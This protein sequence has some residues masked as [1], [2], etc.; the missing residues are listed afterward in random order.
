[1]GRNPWVKLG[2]VSAPGFAFGSSVLA[3]ALGERLE[4]AS[5]GTGDLLLLVQALKALAWMVLLPVLLAAARGRYRGFARFALAYN[6]ALILALVVVTEIFFAVPVPPTHPQ[7]LLIE[8]LRRRHEEIST[9][10]HGS[11]FM[12]GKANELGW[13]DRN[14]EF[15][16]KP[17]RIVFIGDSMLEVRSRRRLALRVEDRFRKSRPV[18]VI[19][20]SMTGSDPKDYRF[21]LNE[22]ALDYH[23][24]HIFIFLYGPNDFELTPPYEAYRPRAI[25]VTPGTIEAV[26]Q[27]GLPPEVLRRLEALQGIV[28]PDRPGF[29]QAVGGRLTQT[30]SQLLYTAAVA[31]S[32]AETRTFL[33]STWT[34]LKSLGVKAVELASLG[35]KALGRPV[36]N[37]P[38]PQ[39]WS[40]PEFKEQEKTVYKLPRQ[41]RLRALAELYARNMHYPAGPVYQLLRKQTP[42][43]QAWL[44]EEQDM[45]WFLAVPLNRLSGLELTPGPEDDGLRRFNADRVEMYGRLLREMS[46][47]AEK[48]GSRLT[49]VFIPTP[50]LADRDFIHFWK[51]KPP[52]EWSAQ[53]YSRVL[54]KVSGRVSLIDLGREPDR[55]RGGYWPLDGHWTDR[56]N[57]IAADILAEFIRSDPYSALKE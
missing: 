57:D 48:H 42:E 51:G 52:T 45:L 21:R 17:R 19:N 47:T 13:M 53:S 39:W 1:M 38:D 31:Y 20:L 33:H 5:D 50:G 14:H 4:Q 34:R 40:R 23:P 28:Y 35:L 24:D 36:P 12:P 26:R 11:L 29:L 6:L 15:A 41:Q 56:A 2:L 49:Y 7:T 3:R 32:D 30:Q 44:V 55:F 43:M 10:Y 54:S 46:E 16:K 25:R 37:F 9:P 18:E 22:Y 8:Q 27:L